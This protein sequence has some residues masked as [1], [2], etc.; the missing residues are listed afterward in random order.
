MSSQLPPPPEGRTS[1]FPYSILWEDFAHIW[2]R[3]EDARDV[4]GAYE[5]LLAEAAPRKLCLSAEPSRARIRS[6]IGPLELCPRAADELEAKLYRIAAAYRIPQLTN[7]LG[8]GATATKKQLKKIA[9]ASEALAELLKGM[10]LEHEVVLGFLRAQVDTTQ[11]PLFHFKALVKELGDLTRAAQIMADEMP[12]M[13]RGTSANI[14]QARLMEA[15]T[16]VIGN[17]AKAPFEVLQ[18]DSAGRNPRA[19]N[20]PAKVLFAY[21]DLVDPGMTDSTKVRLF[22]GHN[23]G[24]KFVTWKELQELPP[25]GWPFHEARKKLTR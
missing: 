11:Q 8:F 22:L 18:A 23:H 17:A 13:P 21:L 1:G 14:I 20:T 5:T 7:M 10:P 24:P 9:A 4:E 12:Q 3:L 2:E 6:I 19:K 25:E 16:R 15:A